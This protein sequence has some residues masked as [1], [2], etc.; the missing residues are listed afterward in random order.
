MGVVQGV[1]EGHIQRNG[2][3][4]MQGGCIQTAGEVG[5]RTSGE[6]YTKVEI[7][8]APLNFDKEVGTLLVSP[9]KAVLGELT[10]LSRSRMPIPPTFCTKQNI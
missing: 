5:A 4:T 2:N 9:L 8:A 6:K 1:S 10:S 7:A 3:H